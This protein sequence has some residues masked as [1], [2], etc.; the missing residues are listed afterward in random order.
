MAFLLHYT[1]SLWA[2]EAEEPDFQTQQRA[3]LCE[4]TEGIEGRGLIL[5]GI[6]TGA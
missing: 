4:Q 1:I 5:H 2:K 6:F 3:A